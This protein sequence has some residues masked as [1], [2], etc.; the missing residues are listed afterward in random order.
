VPETLSRSRSGEISSVL[1]LLHGDGGFSARSLIAELGR[2]A[3]DC[4]IPGAFTTSTLIRLRRLFVIALRVL[5][6]DSR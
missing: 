4:A 5:F 1:F 2:R 3:S 6:H